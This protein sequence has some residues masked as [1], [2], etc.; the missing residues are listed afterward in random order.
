VL[1]GALA[2]PQARPGIAGAVREGHVVSGIALAVPGAAEPAQ[3]AFDTLR[4][5]LGVA[6]SDRTFGT[7][8]A[9]R[10]GYSGA[11]AESDVARA[12]RV[13]VTVDPENRFR[14]NRDFT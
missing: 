5:A 1:G 2:A 13:K 14:G 9:P 7:F 3:R 8:L 10:V 6:A 12:A 11:Y 4:G